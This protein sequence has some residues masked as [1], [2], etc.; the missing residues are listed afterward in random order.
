[1]LGHPL[2]SALGH[3]PR[4]LGGFLGNTGGQPCRG[5]GSQLSREPDIRVSAQAR[6]PAPA[7]RV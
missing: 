5:L 7:E 1:M 3:F 2:L 6:D 4:G